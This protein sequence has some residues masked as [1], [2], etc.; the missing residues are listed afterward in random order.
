MD[1]SD[2]RKKWSISPLYLVFSWL[3]FTPDDELV[4]FPVTESF[5]SCVKLLVLFK[6]TRWNWV[7]IWNRIWTCLKY[8]NFNWRACDLIQLT[9]TIGL[10]CICILLNFSNLVV[11]NLLALRLYGICRF[12]SSMFSFWAACSMFSSLIAHLLV[13]YLLL[14]RCIARSFPFCFSDKMGVVLSI[15]TVMFLSTLCDLKLMPTFWIWFLTSQATSEK[16]NKSISTRDCED[17]KS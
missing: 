6:V 16:F 13:C 17:K 3:D 7:C 5:I 10:V 14:K 15:V 1:R 4:V 8:C 2:S 11:V 9:H 12:A